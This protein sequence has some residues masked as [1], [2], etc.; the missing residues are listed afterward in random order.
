MVFKVKKVRNVL[1]TIT[2]VC[3]LNNLTAGQFLDENGRLKKTIQKNGSDGYM[4]LDENGQAET[5]IQEN[6]DNG[7]MI[8]DSEGHAKGFYQ[9]D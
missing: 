6:G 7:Y 9:E 2:S 5:Y 8:L 1:L 4:I 3:F